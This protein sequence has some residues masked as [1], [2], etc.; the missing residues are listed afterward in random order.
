M[1]TPRPP[2]FTGR[3]QG[4]SKFREA[5][6]GARNRMEIARSQGIQG[7]LDFLG[8]IASFFLGMRAI[9]KVDWIGNSIGEQQG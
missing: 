4:S 7:I 5:N 6:L 2:L 1:P 8:R 3:R 9:E